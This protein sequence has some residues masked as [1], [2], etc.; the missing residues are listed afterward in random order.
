ML[1]IYNLFYRI[2]AWIFK[3]ILTAA[4]KKMILYNMPR[5]KIFMC[6]Y[7]LLYIKHM[8]LFKQ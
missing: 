7:I 6:F 8:N 3:V 1:A 5:N 4:R 2:T